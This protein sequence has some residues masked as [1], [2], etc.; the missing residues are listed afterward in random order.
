MTSHAR[1]SSHVACGTL[2]GAERS[3][4]VTAPPR[5]TALRHHVACMGLLCALVQR[6]RLHTRGHTKAMGVPVIV[7]EEELGLTIVSLTDLRYR[8]AETAQ[9]F[10]CFVNVHRIPLQ[11][12][13][14]IVLWL[15]GRTR[16]PI[17]HEAHVF[18]MEHAEDK[19][20]FLSH[21][22]VHP[23]AEPVDP[24]AQSFV[25]VDARDDR[26]ARSDGHPDLLIA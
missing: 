11:P 21:L 25:Q 22:R 18:F 6:A 15:D 7:R 5:A 10:S 2:L 24:K 4:G 13:A 8:V 12:N 14:F 1:A 9:A 26:Y 19:A 16:S 17:E 20:T 3:K 23:K